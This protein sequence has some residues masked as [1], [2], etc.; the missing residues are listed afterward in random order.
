MNDVLQ[1]FATHRPS[2]TGGRVQHAL[3]RLVR[4]TIGGTVLYSSTR[5]TAWSG[6]PQQMHVTAHALANYYGQRCALTYDEQARSVRVHDT[7]DGSACA[8]DQ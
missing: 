6:G 5:H 8:R 3:H 4:D 7:A 2:T 1:L